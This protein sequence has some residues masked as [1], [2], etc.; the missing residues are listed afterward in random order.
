MAIYSAA[1]QIN[2][3][4]IATP[5]LDFVASAFD[6]PKFIELG[7]QNCLASSTSNWGFGYSPTTSIQWGSIRLIAEDPSNI[8]PCLTSAGTTWT[9]APT[10]PSKYLRRVALP[11]IA[12]IYLILTFPRGIGIAPNQSL[13]LWNISATAS[14]IIVWGA[15]DE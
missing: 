3:P 12:G 14:P 1:F 7:I 10:V 11:S 15:L 5:A 2:Q 8:Q 9:Q 6:S 4:T 13:V